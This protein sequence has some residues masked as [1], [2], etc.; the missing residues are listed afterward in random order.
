MT[1][2]MP[3][4]KRTAWV[5][6]LAGGR[7][8]TVVSAGDPRRNQISALSNDLYVNRLMAHSLTAQPMQSQR[9]RPHRILIWSI[10]AVAALLALGFALRAAD[11]S[12]LW[13]IVHENCEPIQQRL[14]QPGKCQLVALPHHPRE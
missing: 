9:Y 8:V 4:C 14:G 11:S 2:S 7:G 10:V 3:G 12:T 5:W 6:R 1:V 13:R